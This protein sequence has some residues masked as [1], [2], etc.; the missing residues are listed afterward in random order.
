MPGRRVRLT[1]VINNDSSEYKHIKFRK[2]EQ[3]HDEHES[4]KG[5]A[6]C[7]LQYGKVNNLLVFWYMWFDPELKVFSKYMLYGYASHV[8][9]AST[10][11]SQFVNEIEYNH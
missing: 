8:I 7:V 5:T 3:R 2:H 4:S 1:L 11:Q 10:M 6:Q 9:K